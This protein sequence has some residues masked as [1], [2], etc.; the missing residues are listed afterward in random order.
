MV[1]GTS[2]GA[3]IAGLIAAGRS[4]AE[5]EAVY[6]K[7]VKKVFQ[8]AGVFA[9]RFLNPPEY[10]KKSY[11]EL[12][13]QEIGPA[14]TLQDVCLKSGTDLLITSKDV[15]EGEETFFSCFVVDKSTAVGTYKEI[16]LR[17]AL[18]ATMSAPTFFNP[19]ERFVDGGVTT[20][21]NPS[22]AAIIEAVQFGPTD[23]YKIAN[24]TVFSF[25]T[26]YRNQLVEP[27]NV[28]NPKGLDVKFWLSWLMS[29]AGSDASDMQSDILRR[30]RS[31][32]NW[33]TAGS[34]FRW[35][36]PP[37]TNWTTCR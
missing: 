36:A 14:T 18:E 3:I 8:S 7:L 20:Y 9:N 10:T 6:Q 37:C 15:A 12:L 33:T 24:L 19:L 4:A 34:R 27:K 22:L 30:G 29:E 35:I 13:K 16:L 21:N 31:Y 32:P 2:T 5:I 17:A 11:R 1:A 28:V 25:G 23:K 26:G